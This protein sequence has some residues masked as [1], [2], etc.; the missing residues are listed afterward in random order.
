MTTNILLAAF[1]PLIMKITPTFNEGLIAI[2]AIAVL[3][4]V[5]VV[6]RS[7]IIRMLS[8]VRGQSQNKKH[9]ARYEREQAYSKFKQSRKSRIASA[10]AMRTYKPFVKN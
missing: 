1:S 9:Q 6:S 2:V 3:I 7:S 5:L 8:L 10:R 4:A